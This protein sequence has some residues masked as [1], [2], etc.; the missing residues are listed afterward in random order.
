MNYSDLIY[1]IFIIL[2]IIFA[3]Y[4]LSKVNIKEKYMET[5]SKANR[6]MLDLEKISKNIESEYKP[7]PI[8]LTSYEQEQE[9]NAIISYEELVKNI[10]NGY[11]YDE[12][13]KSNDDEIS[14]KKV[15]LDKI[16]NQIDKPQEHIEVKLIS[17]DKEE[18]FLA[19]LKQLQKELN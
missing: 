11:S 5:V 7:E 17:Y 8:E 13:Y 4:L 6:D 9:D 10:D 1:I 16:T 14:V 15:D 2:S 3:V 19:A 12:S 18:A